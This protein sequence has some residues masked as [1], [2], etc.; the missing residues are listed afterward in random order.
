[1]GAA[2]KEKPSDIED[3]GDIKEETINNEENEFTNT[4]EIRNIAHILNKYG[5]KRKCP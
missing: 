4:G 1:M 2:L 5:R 3:D